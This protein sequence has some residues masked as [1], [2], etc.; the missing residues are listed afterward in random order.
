MIELGSVASEVVRHWRPLVRAQLIEQIIGVGD[1][2]RRSSAIAHGLAQRVASVVEA[3]ETL[4]ALGIRHRADT[5]GR[6]I[7]EDRADS[8]AIV[9]SDRIAIGV[10][11]EGSGVIQP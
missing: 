6:V 9:E 2:P 7:P 5:I 1:G 10:V 8:I 4:A 11:L 3:Q